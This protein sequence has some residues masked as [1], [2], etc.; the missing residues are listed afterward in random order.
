MKNEKYKKGSGIFRTFF[1]SRELTQML[2]TQV[3]VNFQFSIL[4]FQF[5]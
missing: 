4:N 2:V 5:T 3:L 1:M